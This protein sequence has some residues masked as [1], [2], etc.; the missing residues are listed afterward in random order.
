MLLTT[1]ER[2]TTLPQVSLPYSQLEVIFNHT[3][4]WM[5]RSRLD[6]AELRCLWSCGCGHVAMVT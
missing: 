6:P 2:D 5:S 1:E 4:L 3:N